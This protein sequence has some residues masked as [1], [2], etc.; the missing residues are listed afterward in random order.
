LLVDAAARLA[1]AGLALLAA[2]VTGVVLLIFLVTV[3]PGAGIA[4]AVTVGAGL[5]G[6]W[7]VLPLRARKRAERRRIRS[8]RSD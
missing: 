6:L 3:G 7:A 2:A 5:V 1:E 8:D 4:A